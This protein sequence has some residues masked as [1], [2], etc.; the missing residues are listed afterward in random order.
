MEPYFS[1]ST[2]SRLTSE[3]NSK[4]CK[5]TEVLLNFVFFDRASPYNNNNNNNTWNITHNTES[6]TV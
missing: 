5:E 4:L 6:T 3:E 2:N 1:N